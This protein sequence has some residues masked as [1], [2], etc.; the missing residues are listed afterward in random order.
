M[1]TRNLKPTFQTLE[2]MLKIVW[3]SG[4]V[5]CLHRNR[6]MSVKLLSFPTKLERDSVGYSLNVAHAICSLCKIC[7]IMKSAKY[8][9]TPKN[10]LVAPTKLP[11]T[12]LL[13]LTNWSSYMD[14]CCCCFKE[15]LRAILLKPQNRSTTGL[16]PKAGKLS[17]S[18]SMKSLEKKMRIYHSPNKF[19][20][21][22]FSN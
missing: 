3:C 5:L 19:L 21:L 15:Q 10:Y 9:S 22:I 18:F 12:V 7:T 20:N 17:R 6:L 13:T 16:Y 14:F 11:F 4:N 1:M 2:V 8:R